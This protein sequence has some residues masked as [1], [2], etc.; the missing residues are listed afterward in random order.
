M[1][2]C[3]HTDFR[4]KGD[5]FFF[6]SCVWNNTKDG[7]SLNKNGPGGSLSGV[8]KLVKKT[9]RGHPR[10]EFWI[11]TFVTVHKGLS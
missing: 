11:V 9:C 10:V 6:L 3:A 5:F 7:E 4:N 8:Y 2:V 1:S